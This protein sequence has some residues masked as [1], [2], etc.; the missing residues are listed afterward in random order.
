VLRF[1]KDLEFHFS[2][3]SSKNVILILPLD[4]DFSKKAI[5]K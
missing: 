2:L 5:S 1:L 4:S 3:F